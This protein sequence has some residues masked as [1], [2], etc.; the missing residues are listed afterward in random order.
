[1]PGTTPTRPA[2]APGS[3]TMRAVVLQEK[4]RITLEDVPRPGDP[5]PGEVRIAMHTVGICG[6]DVHYY[7][8][9]AIGGFVVTAPMIL[10]HE[11]SGTVLAIGEG[12]EN[13]AVGDRVVMEPG[14]PDPRSRA[15]REGIYNV[16]PAVRF[17]ATPP[18]DG[19]LAEEVL[20]P[21][22]YTFR[23]PDSLSFA[24]GALIEPFAV[25]MQAATKARLRPGDIAAVVGCGTIGIMTAIAALNGGAARVYVSDLAP[26]KLALIEGIPGLV[27][28]DATKE[29]LAERV[30]RD[31]GGWGPQAVFEAS[32]AAPSYESI[33]DAPA[34]GGVL[35]VVGMP[36]RPVTFDTTKAQV[37]E[38]RIETVF[39]Y[40]NVHQKAI[41]LAAGPG[42]DLAPLVTK[43][44]PVADAVAAFDRGAEGRPT[45]TKL[46]ITFAD[47]E[48]G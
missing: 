17:W 13:L 34:P 15:A 28:V 20:H 3:A 14:V 1:M 9:G 41:D 24:E 45:D 10:G 21:A 7:T 40:A 18:Y 38:L 8:H 39:R 48:E 30:R 44:F 36:T 31:T 22:E 29:S 2:T 27:P 37:R 32:G 43:T 6:S 12:V 4:G 23:L 33:W 11:G 16:D 5:G 19:C 42:V 47:P 26:E 25:G 46:Q 35:V